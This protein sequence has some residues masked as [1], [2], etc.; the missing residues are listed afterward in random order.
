MEYNG[1]TASTGI[2]QIFQR[3]YQQADL[4]RSN[5]LSSSEFANLTEK[6]AGLSGGE[7]PG[8]LS[9]TLFNQ[10][11][12]NQNGDLT[13]NEMR[14]QHGHK[15]GQYAEP[16]E[17]EELAVSTVQQMLRQAFEKI[18]EENKPGLHLRE[19]SSVTKA[20]HKEPDRFAPE[21][22]NLPFSRVDQ[23]GDGKLTRDEIL[24]RQE[25]ERQETERQETLARLNG[26]LSPDILRSLLGVEEG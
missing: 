18:D 25:T 7:M 24:A 8:G 11:D 2:Q 3:I 17:A 10:F 26:G 9:E 14:G 13:W 15:V 1:I 21:N 4:D 20:D 22:G 16:E 6:I 5:A 23:N 12:K 19:F